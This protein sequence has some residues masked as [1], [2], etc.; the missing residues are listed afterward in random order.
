MQATKLKVIFTTETQR[1]QSHS[2]KWSCKTLGD[3]T[4]WCYAILFE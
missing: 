4:N 3:R 1:T 2:S